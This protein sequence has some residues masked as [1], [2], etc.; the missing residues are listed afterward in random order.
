MEPYNDSSIFDLVIDHEASN[1]LTDTAKWARLLSILG[2]IVSILMVFA[3]LFIAFTGASLSSFGT[4]IRS[5]GPIL[6]I[7]Y[8]VLGFVYM[9]PSWMLLRFASGMPPA[10]KKNDQVL[11]NDALKNL[12]SCFRFW[13]V[14]SVI[15]IA[16]YVLVIAGS[17]V[18]ASLR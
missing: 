11:V 14:L 1:Y 15:I 3:G 17:M 18:F 16:L 13:G 5:I 2:L 10:L 6:G 4:G 12:N 7:S 9:Y 8:L